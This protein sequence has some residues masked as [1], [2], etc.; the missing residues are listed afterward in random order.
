MPEIVPSNMKCIIVIQAGILSIDWKNIQNH[1]QDKV[2]DEEDCYMVFKQQFHL[3][4]ELARWL[5]GELVL[6]R[7]G[8]IARWRAGELVI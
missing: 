3:K 5:A 2:T 7:T 6:L 4:I 8:V 1:Q